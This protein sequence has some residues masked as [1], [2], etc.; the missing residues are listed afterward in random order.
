MVWLLLTGKGGDKHQRVER[1]ENTF[2]AKVMKQVR[3]TIFRQWRQC[4][5]IAFRGL[6][7]ILNGHIKWC[8]FLVVFVLFV[9]R[10]IAEQ[11]LRRQSDKQLGT[12]GGGCRKICMVIRRRIM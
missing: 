4:G 6:N 2:Y 3:W 9:W 5:N 7:A 1:D 11:K 10:T 12:I 8:W